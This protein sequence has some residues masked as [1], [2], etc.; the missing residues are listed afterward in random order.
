MTTISREATSESLMALPES[1]PETLETSKVDYSDSIRVKIRAY[2]FMVYEL[3]ANDKDALA[4]LYH[5]MA[6]EQRKEPDFD[7]ILALVEAAWLTPQAEQS[8]MAEILRVKN[9]LRSLIARGTYHPDQ[10]RGVGRIIAFNT[11]GS[12]L[13]AVACVDRA[14]SE[15]L[16]ERKAALNV[17]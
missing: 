3:S 1:S 7:T 15:G 12:A 10:V 2:A 9:C 11:S 14:I 8:P 16:A 13:I 17:Q 4:C 6:T 5:D